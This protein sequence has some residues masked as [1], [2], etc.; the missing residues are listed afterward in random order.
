[1]GDPSNCKS[2]KTTFQSLKNCFLIFPSRHRW[3]QAVSFSAA[4]PAAQSAI[5]NGR[6]IWKISKN[7]FSEPEKLF[8]CFSPPDT[9]E[10]RQWAFQLLSQLPKAQFAIGD[11]SGKFQKTTFQ[12]LKSCFFDFPL[13]TPLR[14]GSELFSCFSSCPKRNLQWE[15]HPTGKF[16]KNNFSGSEKLFFDFTSQNP[17][18]QSQKGSGKLCHLPTPGHM[19]EHAWSHKNRENSESWWNEAR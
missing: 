10:S 13:Q 6:P 1:M 12:S 9:V 19:F 16:Q 5:C 7:N 4:F 11:P 14:A 15:T 18:P 17:H 8:F 3:E 2:Q